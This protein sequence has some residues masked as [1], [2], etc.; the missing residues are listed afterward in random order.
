[1]RNRR[2]VI[3]PALAL[4]LC[5]FATI[6]AGSDESFAAKST[7]KATAKSSKTTA[8]SSKTTKTTK[9]TAKITLGAVRQTQLARDQVRAK[10]AK[11]AA[12]V[13]A[14]KA[15][16]RRASAAFADL[17][18]SVRVTSV[19]LDRAR[20]SAAKASSDAANAQVRQRTIEAN[21]EKLSSTRLES[22]LAAYAQPAASSLDNYLDAGDAAEAGRR[23]ILDRLAKRGTANALDEMQ[24]LQED[25]NIQRIL[26]ERAQRKASAYRTSV[27]TK[28]A[29]YQSARK[30]QGTFADQLENRLEAQLSEAAGLA[31]LD[32]GLSARLTSQNDALAK[33]LA[34]AGAGGR[35]G[36]KLSV[37]EIAAG[38]GGDTHGIKVASA[39]RGKLAAMVSAAQ[40]DGV[41]LTG[42]GYRSPAAQVQLR[43]AHCGS[44]SFAIY[45]ARA[46]SCRPP[47]ARPGA[48]MHERGLAID[49][50]EG[51]RTL[52]RGSRG[53]AWLRKNAGR[54]GFLNLPSEAWHWS[55]NGR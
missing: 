20:R 46:S 11:A 1:M 16:Q 50:Q 34:A 28:L 2:G 19:A 5:M 22:A 31:D 38:G 29:S 9:K 7:S 47:T 49:F 55:V 44:S 3:A 6:V 32:K 35:G 52:T 23:Q 40:R 18:S 51:G 21:I 27:A 39:I 30:K 45:Q 54:Y 43:I 41:F 17:T 42:G 8:K 53:Y 13:S 33:Q 4:V 14:L 37:A 25:L 10:R 48:S 26:A 12:K 36:G 24:A 15:T